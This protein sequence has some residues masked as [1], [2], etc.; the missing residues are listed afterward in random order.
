MKIFK[1]LD[2]IAPEVKLSVMGYESYKSVTG[3]FF[4]V[5][6]GILS[7]LAFSAFGRD[8]FQ[9]KSPIIIPKIVMKEYS[10]TTVKTLQS[11]LQ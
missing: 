7:I 11:C 3:G 2:F 5:L 1:K 6:L 9:K 8:I 10:I 4:S